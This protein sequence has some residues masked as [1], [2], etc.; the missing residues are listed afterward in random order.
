[1]V[2]EFLLNTKINQTKE[3]SSGDENAKNGA[4]WFYIRQRT[5]KV[6]QIIIINNIFY[7]LIAREEDKKKT[8]KYKKST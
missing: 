2:L 5:L 4:C 6:C 8:K 3:I 7:C 1:L